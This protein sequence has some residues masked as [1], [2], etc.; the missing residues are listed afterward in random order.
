[1]AAKWEYLKAE[2]SVVTKESVMGYKSA[3]WWA[4]LMELPSELK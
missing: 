1:M 4:A 3:I 2:S